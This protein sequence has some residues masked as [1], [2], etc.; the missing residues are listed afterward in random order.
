MPYGSL[1]IDTLTASTGQVFS[2]ASS[3]MRNRIINGA[4]V[5]DQRNAGASVTPTTSVYTLDRWSP[6]L[7][8][9]SKFSFQQVTDAPTG[10][11]YSTKV[12]SLSAYTITSGDYF[13]HRQNIE[14]YNTADLGFGGSTP[15]T[16]TISFWVKSSLTGSFSVSIYN[17]DGSRAYPALYTINSANTWEYKT[18]TIAGS[19]SGTWG[20]T[21]GIGITIAFGL[22]GGSTYSSTAGSWNTSG[23][24]TPFATGATQIVST[25]AA[26]WQVTGVQL[27][28]GSVASQ[29]EYRQYGTEL[30]LCQRYYYRVYTTNFVGQGYIVGTGDGTR[31]ATIFFPASMRATPS[32]SATW[33]GGTPGTQY[34][35]T[36]SGQIYVVSASTGA[37]EYAFSNVIADAEL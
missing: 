14:G 23:S 24:W 8:Q 18:I 36:N 20:T 9:S 1:A 29:F 4:M 3:I 22:G 7:S 32:L 6:Q 2:P 31:R 27:E 25:N 34:L 26:T 19:N 13:L 12:T 28:A 37:T 15:S 35:N 10:F 17:N 5:I 33:N 21:N 11:S 30:A 16:V